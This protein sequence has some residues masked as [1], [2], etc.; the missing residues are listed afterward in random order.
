MIYLAILNINVFM[1]FTIHK[2]VKNYIYDLWFLF[3]SDDSPIEM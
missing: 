1:L 3:S 2:F